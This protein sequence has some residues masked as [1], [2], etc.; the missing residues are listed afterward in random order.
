[1]GLARLLVRRTKAGGQSRPTNVHADISTFF[2][3]TDTANFETIKGANNLNFL[4]QEATSARLRC[5]QASF[6]VIAVLV[7]MCPVSEPTASSL[8]QRSW[9][10]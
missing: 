3:V 9:Q 7:S 8:C 5:S 6:L 10:S 2:G 4:P 1:M